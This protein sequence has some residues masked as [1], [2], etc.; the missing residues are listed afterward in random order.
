MLPPWVLV[1]PS[2][3]AFVPLSARKQPLA[4]T[5]YIKS[6]GLRA[7]TAC[8]CPSNFPPHVDQLV[9]DLPQ[10]APAPQPAGGF[11]S[12]LSALCG[13]TAPRVGV[14]APCLA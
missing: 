14:P 5:G 1:R 8:R 13:P 9:A 3:C 12:M 7:F 2:F 11:G 4:R 10:L 6:R